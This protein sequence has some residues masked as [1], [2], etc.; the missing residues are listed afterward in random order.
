MGKYYP[1]RDWPP[2]QCAQ[3][4][5]TFTKAPN[6]SQASWETRRYCSRLCATGALEGRVAHNRGVPGMPW[7]LERRERHAATVAANTLIVRTSEWSGG[8]W[9]R[10]RRYVLER[11]DYTCQECGLRE[12]RIMTV[13]HKIPRSIEPALMYDPDNA[14]TL[15]PNDHARKTIADRETIRAHRAAAVTT[16][17]PA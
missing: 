3:C 2:K 4:G 7:T 10:I 13:D 6:A 8:T 16:L 9:K 11:D 15:C 17:A 1:K 5:E 14:T 12:P